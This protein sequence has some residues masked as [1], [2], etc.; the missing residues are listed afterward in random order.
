M[1]GAPNEGEIVEK[2]NQMGGRSPVQFILDILI[3]SEENLG[4]KVTY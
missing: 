3:I 1:F 2:V 4:K